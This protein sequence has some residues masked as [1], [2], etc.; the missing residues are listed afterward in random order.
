MKKRDYLNIIIVELLFAAFVLILT[1]GEFIYGSTLD[2]M[3]QH[4]AFPEYFRNLFY[5]TKNIFPNFAFNIGAGQN[6]FNFSY[7]GLFSP[8]TIFSY[9]L[10]MVKMIDYMQAVSIIGCG[11]SIILFYVWIK[12]RFSSNQT[13]FLTLLFTLASPLIFHSH[14]HIM[15]TSYLP[16][17]LMALIAVDRYFKSNKRVLLCLSVFLLTMTNY[18]FAFSSL[19]SI[20]VYG[21]Y[22]YLEANKKIKLKT[23]IKDG[24]NFLLPILIG[25]LMSS[26]LLLPTIYAIFNGRAAT[27]VDLNYKLLLTPKVNYLYVLYYSYAMGLT[28]ISLISLFYAF[29]NKKKQDIMVAIMFLLII[30]LP[31][32][33]YLLNG[34]MYINAKALIPFIPIILILVGNMMS[35]LTPKKMLIAIIMYT[36][37]GVLYLQDTSVIVSFTFIIDT[38]L[39]YCSLIVYFIS[40]SPKVFYITSVLLAFFVVLG[41]NL[42]DILVS[43]ATYLAITSDQKKLSNYDLTDNNIYRF[44]DEKKSFYNP[45]Y[46]AKMNYYQTSVYSSLANKNYNNFIFNEFNNH[47]EYR[48]S[49]LMVQNTNLLYNAYMGVKNI[50]TNKSN[51]LDYQKKDKELYT[52]EN[53]YPL[54]YINPKV[55]S[56]S[57]FDQLKYPYNIEALMNYTIVDNI[58]SSAYQ[59]QIKEVK[60]KYQI[61]KKKNLVIKEKKG[62]YQITAKD[63]ARL[64]LLLNK[65]LNKQLLFITLKMEYNQDCKQGDTSITINGIKNK[66]SCSTW[67]Y[68]NHNYEFKY[69]IASKDDLRVL[70]ISFDKG[71]YVIS[72]IKTYTI[73]QDFYQ[74]TRAT[75]TP[76]V[77]DQKLTKGDQIYGKI[78]VKESGYFALSIPYDK[79]FRIYVD[80]QKVAYQMVNKAF[81]GFYLNKGNHQIKIVYQAP[82]FNIG[83]GLSIIGLAGLGYLIYQERRKKHE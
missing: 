79:G 34:T 59:S 12:K 44:G 58:K 52:N 71:K 60:L 42:D 32:I 81:I 15:F 25:V 82:L 56:T 8:I 80:K 62:V 69:L 48:N 26:L 7:Y 40:K 72:H 49:A 38:I 6:I 78:T 27:S 64:E 66:L 16:F 77:F 75:L 4:Y 31:I 50:Y 9:L 24:L 2:W 51:L 68:H 67:K 22:C 28:A 14:R 63:N 13:L 23:F 61:P 18:Y 20:V 37:L 73:N 5:A 70:K 36:I 21:I 39:I 3:S 54:G 17:L 46:V 35:N 65:P 33:L 1:R 19:I 57:D 10:P 29:L 30:M 11:V 47:I 55:L 41:M 83:K 45:N 76:F 74:K 53:V 43:K